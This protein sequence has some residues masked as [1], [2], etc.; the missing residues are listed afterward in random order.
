MRAT[1]TSVRFARR[2][3]F[4]DLDVQGA[5]WLLFNAS[6]SPGAVEARRALDAKVLRI[7]IGTHDSAQDGQRFSVREAELVRIFTAFG[8]EPSFT[9]GVS[10]DSCG[11]VP[12]RGSTRPSPWGPICMADGAFGFVNVPLRRK[13]RRRK[14]K[15]ARIY[16]TT[17]IPSR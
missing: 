9:L 3:D 8:W 7:H 14:E 4:V 16:R 15:P 6:A 2:A 10:A 1:Q 17:R 12:E 13:L 5:E 11:N